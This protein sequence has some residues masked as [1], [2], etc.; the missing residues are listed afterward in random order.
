VQ[1]LVAQL[2]NRLVESI[3]QRIQT[4]QVKAALAANSELIL[5]YWEN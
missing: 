3:K 2:Y 1:Q 5:H 4:A